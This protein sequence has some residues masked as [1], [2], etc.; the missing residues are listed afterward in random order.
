MIGT[1]TLRGK[2]QR[3]YVTWDSDLNTAGSLIP[4]PLLG[5]TSPSSLKFSSP[6]RSP[7][8]LSLAQTL[9]PCPPVEITGVPRLGSG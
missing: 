8:A 5:I 4:E 6:I 9:T 2:A 1:L 7:Q 3:G